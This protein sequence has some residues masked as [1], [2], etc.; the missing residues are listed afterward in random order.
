[1]TIRTLTHIHRLLQAEAQKA[2]A[3]YRAAR[4]LQH[5]Y[6]DRAADPELIRSQK[7]AADKFW[8]EYSAALDAL[9]AFENEEWK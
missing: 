6:E 9:V 3:T 7:A 5:E 4:A 2:Q 8:S 1:M